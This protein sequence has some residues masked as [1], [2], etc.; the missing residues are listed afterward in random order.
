[1]VDRRAPGHHRLVDERADHEAVLAHCPT[2][3]GRELHRAVDARA[4]AKYTLAEADHELDAAREEL[5]G[6]GPLRRV[7]SSG[8][9][10]HARAEE[11]LA[12]AD[13]MLPRRPSD[14]AKADER[15]AALAAHQT[16]RDAFLAREGWRSERIEAIDDELAQHWAPGV[17]GRD[18]V[19]SQPPSGLLA[20]SAG[21]SGRRDRRRPG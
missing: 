13:E 19:D 12:L 6:L 1:V 21:W 10:A 17:L 18:A 14:L 16:D 15:I 20:R 8:R 11:R 2:D 9:V 7:R 3:R 5:G 4:T